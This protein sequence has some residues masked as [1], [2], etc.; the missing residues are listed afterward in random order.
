MLQI[1]IEEKQQEL[2]EL[3][4]IRDASVEEKVRPTLKNAS[5]GE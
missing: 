2:S 5:S 3:Q 1:M 4:Q